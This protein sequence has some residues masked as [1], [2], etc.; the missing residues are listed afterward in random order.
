MTRRDAI[1]PVLL[2][3]L[4]APAASR[5]EEYSGGADANAGIASATAGSLSI[6]TKTGA[7]I[8]VRKI[9]SGSVSSH[10][11]GHTVTIER[12]DELAGGWNAIAHAVAK[13]NGSFAARWKPDAR[14]GQERIRA[15]VDSSTATAAAAAPEI[16]ITVFRPGKATWYGPGFY[17][18]KTACGQKLTKTL[19]G[20]AHKTLPCGTPITILYKG[21]TVTVPVVD[22]GPFANGANWDI[23]GATAQSLGFA[24]T[25]RIGTIA[26]TD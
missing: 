23:T 4:A 18:N 11:A 19:Q 22:R 10:D 13:S 15:T 9:F 16:A 24:T 17:G 12:Y 5:A 1:M 8:G 20:V 2:L 21:R 26:A 7:L 6:S 25:A 14:V 3:A